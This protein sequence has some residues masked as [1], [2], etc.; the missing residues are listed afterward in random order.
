MNDRGASIKFIAYGGIITA[1]NVPDRWGKLDNVVLGF[2]ELA[3][4][5]SLTPYFGALIGRYANRRPVR[6]MNCDEFGDN[7]AV[8]MAGDPLMAARYRRSCF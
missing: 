1:I 8:L 5:E 3:D 6:G 2:K 7:V 4:Y